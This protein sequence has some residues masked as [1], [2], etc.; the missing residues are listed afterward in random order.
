MNEK[1][2]ETLLNKARNYES[3][4]TDTVAGQEYIEK[5]ADTLR[6][7]GDCYFNSGNFEAALKCYLEACEHHKNL[8]YTVSV[9]MDSERIAK[10][11]RNLGNTE[12]FK[13][14]MAEAANIYA[15]Q[16]EK[17]SMAGN[18][19]SAALLYSDA[20]MAYKALGNSEASKNCFELAA[21]NYREYA[22]ILIE[23]QDY[24]YAA[25]NLSWASMCS[26]AISNLD[27]AVRNADRALA[28]CRNNDI[29]NDNY[30]LA[31]LS[32]AV[33]D[34]DSQKATQT[35]NRIKE[36]LSDSEIKIINLCLQNLA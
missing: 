17:M 31:T 8:N 16:A 7:A 34:G 6:E 13:K 29:T 11:H 33:C 4:A 5:A 20:A 22:E 1:D 9:A 18:L 12:D 30:E 32:K 23:E 2:C 24:G 19:V 3:Q 14:Y 28:L 21:Q 26:F 25:A 35:L 10:C 15:D 36:S 27:E